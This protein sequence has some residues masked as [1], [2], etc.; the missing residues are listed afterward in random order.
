[1]FGHRTPVRKMSSAEKNKD[2]LSQEAEQTQASN[3]RRSI[4][5]WEAAIPSQGSSNP[6]P[7]AAQVAPAA[8]CKAK[9]QSLTQGPTGEVTD[10][11]SVETTTSPKPKYK[12]RT[13]EARAC[14]TSAKLQLGKARNL[15]TDIKNEV[16]QN[17]EHKILS[18]IKR[19]ERA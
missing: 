3:V 9:T 14:L 6:S 13:S 19:K 4:G 11:R 12:N 16:T 2:S 15:R 17:I 8:P 5:E 1:M 18:L 10:R 7:R